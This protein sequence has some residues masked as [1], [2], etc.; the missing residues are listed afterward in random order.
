MSFVAIAIGGGALIGAVGAG[1]AASTQAGAAGNAASLQSQNAQQALQFQEQQW[2]TQ[3]KNMA[4]WLQAGQGAVGQLSNLAQN[5]QPWNQ[6][7][8]APTGATEQNDPGY[9]FRLQQGNQALQNSAAASGNLLTGGTAKAIQQY[10]QDYASNEYS[11]VYNR[12]LGQ[13]Q[14]N[15]NIFEQNQA[16]QFNRLASVAGAGQTAAGQL[17]QQGQG[18]ANNISNT[19][20]GSGQQIGNSLLNQGAATASG[21]AGVANAGIG[22]LSNLA[23]LSMLGPT[24]GIPGIPAGTNPGDTVANLLGGQP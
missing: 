10:G 3:Q 4:P 22:G 18:A 1:F 8:Q 15:Y 21:Y 6:Q 16:N 14:Q 19:L 7:F 20:L 5:F 9:Q 23:Q 2:N 13:Y 17:G 11:N 24:G 12:A